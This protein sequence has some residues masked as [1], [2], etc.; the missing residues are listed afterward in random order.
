MR[1]I[2]TMFMDTAIIMILS[3]W[4]AKISQKDN[5]KAKKAFSIN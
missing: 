2:P 3:I 4:E 5:I 1:L